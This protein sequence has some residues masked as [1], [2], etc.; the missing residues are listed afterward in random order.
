MSSL[1]DKVL[2]VTGGGGAIAGA[3]IDTLA[4]AGARLALVDAHDSP[5]L[6]DRA[7]AI[8]GLALAADLTSVAGA[9]EMVRLTV[10]RF[11]RVDGLVHT[12][13]G[14]AMGRVHEIDPAM[15][16]RM[17][18][19]NVRSLFYATRAVL[20][21]LIAQRDGLLVGISSEPGLTGRAPG[22]SL[23]AAAKS[24]VATFLRSVDG[25]LGGTAIRVGIVFPVGA[26]DTPQ[27][28]RDMPD[29]DSAKYIDPTEIGEAVRFIATRGPRGR[30]LELPVYPAR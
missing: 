21:H 28:R 27:N 12:V 16:D 29:F 8:S 18:D 24:A 3:I 26:V 14:F 4:A 10:E 15:Y 17:F 5:R 20:P 9:E 6:R 22:A 1:N 11:G 13:G 30:I 23:Y 25:E 19:L 2:L 7:A